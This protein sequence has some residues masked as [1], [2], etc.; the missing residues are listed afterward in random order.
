MAEIYCLGRALWG[1]LTGSKT[2]LVCQCYAS[3][4]L[5]NRECYMLNFDGRW[6]FQ[7]PGSIS[8]DVQEEILSKI[9]VRVATS[10]RRQDVLETFKRRFAQAAGKTSSNSSNDSWAETDLR[11][12]MKD[13]A[14]NA[15]LFVEALHDGLIDLTHSHAVIPPWNYV[16]AALGSS[17]YLIDPPNL[18]MS[19]LP[20]PICVPANV[21][22]LDTQANQRIQR[23]LS[24]SE[25]FLIAG[26]YRAAVQEILWLLET[27]STAFQGAEY[28]DGNITG[29]YFNKIISDLRRFNRDRTL[30]RVVDWMESMYGYLSSPS[31]GGI[32]HGALLNENL[33][34]TESEARLYCD[35]TRS[36]ISFLLHE[37]S[38]LGSATL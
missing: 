35:L 20:V 1:E 23:S 11:Q 9:I 38:R 34:I 14:E 19:S 27:I 31:G 24:E 13:A 16:N 17:G 22:S 10:G 3:G 15:P 32:R 18:I 25:T 8:S 29:K 30:S 26:S 5:S 4:V 28:P 7:S 6:R 37:H 12:Y 2:K 21:P 33:E 36:Y